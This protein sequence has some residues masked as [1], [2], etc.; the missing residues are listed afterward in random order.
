[1][2]PHLGVA[3][4]R[5]K[6][7]KVLLVLDDVDCLSQLQVLAEKNQWFGSGSRIIIT[8]EDR[9]V[10]NAHG[11]SHI[12]DVEF[13][14]SEEAFQ[15]FCMHAFGHKR[16]DDGFDELAREVAN[17]AGKLPLGLKILGSTLKGKPKAEWEMTLPMLKTSLNGEIES[18]LKFSYE[19]LDDEYKYLF[20][21][22][23]CFFNNEDQHKVEEILSKKFLYVT[24]A[25]ILVLAEKSFISFD[26]TTGYIHMHDVLA[27]F[28]RETSRKQ[29]V[30]DQFSK[31]QLL[32]DKRD[33]S[34]VLSNDTTDDRRFIGM[35]LSMT[36]KKMKISKKAL[37][38]LSDLEIIRIKGECLSQFERL[39][40][41]LYHSQKIRL[42][43][44]SGFESKCLRSS[45]NSESLVELCMRDSKLKKLWKGTKQLKNLKWMDLSFSED[46]K[47]LPDLSTAINLEELNLTWC[48]SLRKLPS[49]IGNATNLREV[50][51]SEC[52]KL[53]KIPSSIGNATNLRELNLSGC[54]KLVKIP[55][56]I[57]NL[58]N[59][60]KLNLVDC[61][62]LVELPSIE[63]ATKL[64]EL[65]LANCSRLV[66][67]PSFINATKLDL[68]NLSNFSSLLELPP[69]IGTATNLKKLYV[70]G[71]SSLVNVP[72][73]LGDLT[74]LK[75]LD[76]SNCSNMVEL[77]SS[78]GNLQLLS[79]LK[80]RGCS[81][82][83]ALPTNIN[84]KSLF[85]LDL[86]DCSQLKSFPEIST[87]ITYLLLTG[88]SI[89]EVPLSIM[90]WSRL[91]DF[92]MSYF[93]SLKEF[94]H[95]LDIITELQLNEDIQEVPPC[96]KGMS[97]L[98]VL[99][100]QNCKN[101]VSL[102]QFSDSLSYIDADNCQSLETL[103]C[104]FNNPEIRLNF[105]NCFKLKQEARDLIMHTSTSRYAVLPSTQVPACFN[106]RAT[107]G[108]LLTIKLNESPLPKSLR[109][110]ACIMLLK[111]NEETG[112]DNRSIWIEI[113][114]KQNDFE[115]R[116]TP[117]N[118]LIYPV[119]REHIYTFEV[120]AEDVT[121]TELLFQ[122]TSPNNDN[123]KI[124]G[125]D[126]W[127]IGECGVYQI[128]EDQR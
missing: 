115:V 112:D 63:N 68:L 33:I 18:I 44:W 60:Q 26:Y 88:T 117:R 102:P 83:E 105:S 80:M 85:F 64:E 27:Q 73:S 90:S 75:D 42:L 34:E 37:K 40:S 119:L 21:Y 20:L 81:K 4:E 58:T 107:A 3:Q 79:Y 110:K 51:L 69:S 46:L 65:E 118:Y 39:H 106:H 19:A 62:N 28:G 77:P 11:I 5:L 104:S 53:V 23:A 67:L 49:S 123:R 103:D 59:L 72:S 17:L 36:E 25:G 111:T 30:H 55:S 76:L 128:L 89:K 32:T 47:E 98:R 29:F 92:S 41:L 66:K 16:P 61:L 114:D 9:G 54:S 31:Y 94:P 101:L 24:K 84:L 12:Y 91:Y 87:H 70:S 126:N 14:L 109:F 121:S 57:G 96:V 48:E 2:I 38:R 15:I 56:S 7:K 93:E 1:M 82:V 86:T 52:S 10:L 113:M 124:G 13:P 116:C 8:T 6:D 120:E 97:R 22:I 108:G 71:C 125:N 45:F 78:I 43:D 50:N 74:N 122:F 95:A 35:N 100:L 127:K 99:R